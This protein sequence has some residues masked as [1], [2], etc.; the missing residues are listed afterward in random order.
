VSIDLPTVVTVHGVKS[1]LMPSPRWLR[2]MVLENYGR[3]HRLIAV[4]SFVRDRLVQFGARADRITVI[5]NAVDSQ[6]FYPTD[7]DEA[8]SRLGIGELGLV[9]LFNGNLIPLKGVDHLVA[10]F[11]RSAARERGT[12]VIVGDGP[13]RESLLCL[14]GE[15]GVG[16]AI[17]FV[18]AR[19]LPEMP[20]WYQACDVFVMPSMVEGLSM[21]ILEA[22][23][24]ARPV[25]TTLPEVGE[26]DVV[27]D[28]STGLLVASGDVEGLGA[29]IDR[30]RTDGDAARRMGHVARELVA[31]R[32]T[33][34]EVARRTAEIYRETLLEHRCRQGSAPRSQ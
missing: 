28:G 26:H 5:P 24:S 27:S 2:S 15:L 4:S 33:W 6:E 13:E 10:A 3:A 17:L 1:L 19:P 34:P 32:F 11:A 31:E 22:M 14:A 25:I 21:A 8:R 23:S 29:A 12:L 20:L 16:D 30:L 7:P 9:V 18:G